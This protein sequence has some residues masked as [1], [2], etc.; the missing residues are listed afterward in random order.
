MD[1][2][3][4]P[5]CN[6]VVRSDSVKRLGFIATSGDM[7]RSPLQKYQDNV[8][9]NRSLWQTIKYEFVTSLLTDL[10]G[11]LG[12]FLR[13]KIY[14]S[15]LGKIGKGVAIGKGVVIWQPHKLF[16]GDNSIL[17]DYIFIS[18]RGSQEAMVSIGKNTM[19]GRYTTI[20]TRDGIVEIDDHANIGENCRI[21]STSFC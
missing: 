2:N 1:A 9:G 10:P 15:L 21:G 4:R 19:L 5:N 18:V 11:M 8:I 3:N 12:L 20:K 16:I 13:M 6:R 17:R 14:P 7:H